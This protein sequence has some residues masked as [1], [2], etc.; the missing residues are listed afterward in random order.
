MPEY[1]RPARPPSTLAVVLITATASD[2]GREAI[3]SN[4][5]RTHLVSLVGNWKSQL[6]QIADRV[7]NHSLLA[8][9]QIR[10]GVRAPGAGA[11]S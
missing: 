11:D 5:K 6:S 4:R 8:G 9:T 3:E 7:G 2:G 10:G 1:A